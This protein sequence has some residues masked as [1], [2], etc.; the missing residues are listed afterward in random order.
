[1]NIH[2]RFY[3]QRRWIG[4]I[5][6]ASLEGSLLDSLSWSAHVT[7]AFGYND[8]LDQWHMLH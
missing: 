5:T 2:S 1:M 3:A 4:G 8:A 7:D 6:V